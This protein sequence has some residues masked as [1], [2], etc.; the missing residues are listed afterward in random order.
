MHKN[1]IKRTS[2]YDFHVKNG[3]KIIEFAGFYLPIQY[4]GIIQEHEAV[5][6]CA[7][8]FDVSHMGEISVKGQQAEE[9]LQYVMTNDVS[10]LKPGKI[11]YSLM[12]NDNG[13]VVDD[14]IIMKKDENNYLV[15]INASNINKDYDWMQSKKN[16]FNVLLENISE[17]ISQI[18]IQGPK[19]EIILQTITDIKLSEIK[20]FS[21]IENAKVLDCECLISRS[22]YT[23]EDGF[24][25]YLKNTEVSIVTEGLLKN[26]LQ[27]GVKLCGLGAR[28]T[29]RFEAALPLYG[30]E[31]TDDISPIEAG[32][33][34]F[35]KL[36][37][38]D[39]VGKVILDRQKTEGV[40]RKIV[41]FEL[42]DKG[43][44]RS[45]YKVF[46]DGEEIGFVTTGYMSISLN[47]SIG[48]AIIDS[49]HADIENTIDIQV[50]KK[51]LKARIVSKKFLNKNYKK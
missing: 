16:K 44:S 18:A 42:I 38:G 9:F 27:Y 6:N 24:E 4:E 1:D 13:G 11:I 25:I 47:K 28:D 32:L 30:N 36:D 19:S 2:L 8:I 22:G 17:Q 20:F 50:R 40:K 34:M 43:I 15:V 41:G 46:K 10:K 23:G 33:S 51:L 3:G 49:K 26:G 29:L 48:L 7:G 35:V 39:F 12:C 21:F 5:R 14:V 45:E 37:K 31:L